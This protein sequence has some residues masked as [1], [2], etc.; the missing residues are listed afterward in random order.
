MSRG[1]Q[2]I[3][4][5]VVALA[6]TIGTPSEAKAEEDVDFDRLDRAASLQALAL[7]A[8]DAGDWTRARELAETVLTLDDGFAT[9]SSRLV[10]VRGLEREKQYDSALYELR[11][12][13]E[14]SLPEEQIE[15]G[16]RVQARIQARKDGTF[17]RPRRPTD[18]RLAVGITLMVTG[19]LPVVVGGVFVGNDIRWAMQKEPSGTWAA[20]GIPLLAVGATLDVIGLISLIKSVGPRARP[21]ARLDRRPA[22]RLGLSVG[23]RG[24]LWEIGLVGRW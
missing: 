10:L 7:E 21:A 1:L 4:L 20:I 16:R 24:D 18:P 11:E 3:V 6:V 17:R 13:F 5:S 15:E 14:L 19:A 8:A 23:R 22:P 9:A 2:F 12:Y